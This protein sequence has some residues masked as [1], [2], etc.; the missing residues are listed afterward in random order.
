MF[1]KFP[2]FFISLLLLGFLYSLS[3][4]SQAGP[5]SNWY[6]GN[7]AGISF[8]SGSPVALTNG[9]LITTEGVATISDFSGNLL[10]YTNGV[11]VWDRNHSIRP[12]GNGLNGDVSIA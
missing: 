3:L 12:N 6:F 5:N 9:A 2:N 10:F 1:G 4:N 7:A 11:T 8:N